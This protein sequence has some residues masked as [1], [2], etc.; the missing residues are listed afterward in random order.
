[1]DLPIA[2]EEPKHTGFAL[3]TMVLMFNGEVKPIHSLVKGDQLMGDDNT[4]R[5][6]ISTEK[7]PC[8]SFYCVKQI[9][10]FDFT[11][12][13]DNF[14]CL[15]LS[16]IKN[17]LIPTIIC[18][19]KYM[20]NDIVDIRLQDYIRLH[21]TRKR[22]L[23]ACKVA[24]NFTTQSLNF[25]AYTFGLW[26]VDAADS[27][28]TEVSVHDL[29][30]LADVCRDLEKEHKKLEFIR[31]NRFKI[32]MLNETKS[33]A[34]EILKPLGI[35]ETKFIPLVYK[36]NDRDTRLKILAGVMDCEGYCNRNCFE[37]TIKNER[38]VDDVIFIA[39]SVGLY[40]SKTELKRGYHRVIISGDLS[41]IPS[42]TQPLVERKQIKDILH[43]GFTVTESNDINECVKITIDGNGR[44]L[45]S[46][47]TVAHS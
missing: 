21:K 6:V 16:R 15:K 5:S 41:I 25:D 1:M 38:V 20:K 42:K 44:F 4:P 18:E 36:T 27:D 46:D 7:V 10:G 31:D 8:S 26:I 34:E 3:N 30:I 29:D 24:V 28:I 11:I 19:K 32:C 47:F 14:I 2:I 37:L 39:L 40:A 45:L 22:D 9:K 13:K 23:K 43:T 17:P 35:E 12:N 33:F